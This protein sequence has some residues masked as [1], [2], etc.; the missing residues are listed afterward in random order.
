MIEWCIKHSFEFVDV[1]EEIDP[2]GT[3]LT[4]SAFNDFFLFLSLCFTFLSFL[5]LLILLL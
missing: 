3:R 5:F 1:N 2:E 4:T